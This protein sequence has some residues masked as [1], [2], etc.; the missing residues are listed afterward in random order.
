MKTPRIVISSSLKTQKQN[1]NKSEKVESIWNLFV[2]ILLPLILIVTFLAVLDIVRYRIVADRTREDNKILVKE[3]NKLVGK[4]NPNQQ[5]FTKYKQSILDYQKQRLLHAFAEIRTEQLKRFKLYK[6]TSFKDVNLKSAK[7]EDENFKFLCLNLG[8]HVSDNNK[9]N[10][11]RSSLYKNLLAKARIKD[12]LGFRVRKWPNDVEATEE[13]IMIAKKGVISKE[14]RAFIHNRIIEFVNEIKTN[15]L[16]IQCDVLIKI[17]GEL[18]KN[19]EEL[20][21]RSKELVMLMVDQSMTS[22]KR[23][24]YSDLFYKKVTK[25][26][27]KK[28]EEYE[29][30]DETWQQVAKIN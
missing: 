30:L 16:E 12:R 27:R 26:I 5:Y 22:E 15:L 19:P 28:V 18:I 3:I 2:Q 11:Y 8:K 7:I 14:N 10:V 21:K 1:V 13:E 25:T 6:V 4:D 9:K 20:D 23:K 29:F 24:E 17:Y